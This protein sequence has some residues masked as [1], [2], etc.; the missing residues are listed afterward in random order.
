MADPTYVRI[1]EGEPLP[2]ISGN[3]PFRA[4]VVIESRYSPEWQREVSEWLVRSG[5]LYMMAWGPDCLSWDDSVDFANLD[6]FAFGEIPDQSFVLTTW[7]EDDTLEQV[8]WYAGCCADHS[9]VALR[10]TLI[11]HVGA[12]D[13]RARMLQHYADA[14]PSD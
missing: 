12:K 6:Q 2:D 3:A 10:S 14:Q 1:H 11:V 13:E 9:E 7:H 5:C 4:V 8:F